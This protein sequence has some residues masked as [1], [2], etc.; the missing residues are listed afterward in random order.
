MFRTVFVFF[1]GFG[2][3]T[4]L[5]QSYDFTKIKADQDFKEALKQIEKKVK[6]TSDFFKNN[7]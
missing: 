5:H 7:K 2:L 3:S 1:S 4:Y 6:D